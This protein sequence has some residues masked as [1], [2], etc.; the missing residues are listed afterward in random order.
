MSQPIIANTNLHSHASIGNT[1]KKLNGFTI[2]EL[3]IAIVVIGILAA[4]SIVAYNGIQNRASMTKKEVAK[5]NVE[6]ALELYKVDNGSYPETH[7]DFYGVDFEPLE[8]GLSTIGMDI[9]GVEA[10][11]T[12]VDQD[13]QAAGTF[14]KDTLYI[15]T[16]SD[17]GVTYFGIPYHR[18]EVVFTYWDDNESEWVELIKSDGHTNGEYYTDY[19]YTGRLSTDENGQPYDAN[20]Y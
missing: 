4:I 16:Y 13:K 17:S 20:F 2:V 15:A 9:D 18:D 8:P 1:H 10:S 7:N 12:R 14:R 6:K 19:R 11:P 5:S 3:L